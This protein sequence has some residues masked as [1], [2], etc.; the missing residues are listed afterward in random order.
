[1]M[2]YGPTTVVDRQKIRLIREFFAKIPACLADHIMPKSILFLPMDWIY[3]VEN[4]V[5]LCFLTLGSVIWVTRPVKP[6]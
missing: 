1:M 4:E 2:T 5:W 3:V 6:P